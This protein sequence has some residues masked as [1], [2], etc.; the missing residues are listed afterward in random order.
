M[1]VN[2]KENIM[3]I[4]IFG[5]KDKENFYKQ[6]IGNTPEFSIIAICNTLDDLADNYMDN[7]VN[8]DTHY[9]YRI[10]IDYDAYTNNECSDSGYDLSLIIS[11]GIPTIFIHTSTINQKLHKKYKKAEFYKLNN[12]NNGI[13][14]LNLMKEIDQKT[15]K[16]VFNERKSNDLFLF[17]IFFMII[18][19][20]VYLY[21]KFKI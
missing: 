7:I 17:L 16:N 3:N 11:S 15:Q 14:F 6:L 1:L 13:D 12:I 2:G 18:S 20:I 8:S 10:I 9:E 21:F 19:L 4:L 5:N